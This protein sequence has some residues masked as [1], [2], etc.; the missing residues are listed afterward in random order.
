MLL[1]YTIS[2]PFE[3]GI[4]IKSTSLEAHY[5]DEYP[6]ILNCKIVNLGMADLLLATKYKD[7]SL[8]KFGYSGTEQE[9]FS[10]LLNTVNIYKYNEDQNNPD[11]IKK[12]GGNCQAMSLLLATTCKKNGIE[13]KIDY[14]DTHMWNLVKLENI[15]YRVD[16]TKNEMIAMEE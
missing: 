12:Y 10:R 7:L 16:L 1:I 2:S 9:R 14:N 4:K 6:Y 3:L 11:L 15:W 8:P 5:G 13:C